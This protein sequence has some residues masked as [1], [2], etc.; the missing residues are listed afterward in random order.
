MDK[1]E[2]C[3]IDVDDSDYQENGTLHTGVRCD[4]ER[5]TRDAR[6]LEIRDLTRQR[7]EAVAERD[8]LQNILDSHFPEDRA[9]RQKETP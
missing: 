4:L 9:M 8:A 6:D 7:D 2:R 5:V 3:G 1:C